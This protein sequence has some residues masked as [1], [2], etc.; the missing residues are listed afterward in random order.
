MAD[1]GSN[2]LGIGTVRTHWPVFEN[3]RT[4]SELPHDQTQV[5]NSG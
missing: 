5:Y 1:V 3:D 2:D 4:P